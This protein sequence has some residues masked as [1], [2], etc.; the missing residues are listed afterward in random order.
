MYSYFQL[1]CCTVAIGLKTTHYQILQVPPSASFRDIR[2][3]YLQKAKFLHP[4]KN[5]DPSATISFQQINRAY[6][7]LKDT[8]VREL[9]DASLQN[10]CPE[11]TCK[12]HCSCINSP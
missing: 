4:D 5:P 11:I 6:E 9:Y 12:S 8:E 10:E 7:T 1:M 2:T 3:S